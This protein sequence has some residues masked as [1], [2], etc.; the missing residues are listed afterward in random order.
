[1]VSIVVLLP[2]CMWVIRPLGFAPEAAL[3]DLDLP[4][5]GPGVEVVQ[6]L[7]LHGFWQHQVPRGVGGEGSRKY[8][9]LEGMTTSTGQ[10]TSIFLPGEPFSLT[11]KTGRLQSTGSQSQTLLKQTCVHRCKTSFA[12]GSST[13]VRVEHKSGTAAWLSGTLAAPS[14]EWHGLSPPQELWPYQSVFSSL[15]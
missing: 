14:V 7:G 11:E 4:L 13:P 10:Y 5:W 9:A 2:P 8:S 6:L 12:C 1:M 15:L 3:E